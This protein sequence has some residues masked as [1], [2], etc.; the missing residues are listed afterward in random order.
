[1]FGMFTGIATISLVTVTFFLSQ[2]F[3]ETSWLTKIF[4][5]GG[6]AI[7]F[8][9]VVYFIGRQWDSDLQ[10]V[11][12]S[13]SKEGSAHL[14]NE[15]FS[16]LSPFRKIVDEVLNFDHVL[17]HM[18]RLKSGLDATT[19]NVMVADNE[20]N[21][22]YCNESM[23]QNFRSVESE[24]RK[25][26]PNFNVSKL[27]GEN[28]DVFHKNPAHQ[29]G[30]IQNL[31]QTVRTKIRVGTIHFDLIAT[32][33]ID[34]HR[35]RT[36]T[37]IEWKN[38][39]AE[40]MAQDEINEVIQK[41][42]D[43]V[44]DYRVSSANKQGFMKNL[45]DGLN[46]ITATFENVA[47]DVEKFLGSL[48]A[49]DLT[50]RISAQYQG[51]FDSIKQNANRAAEQI[52]STVQSIA[53]SA[54][55]V[56]TASRE[57]STGA[58]ELE[59]RTQQ[60]A[61]SLEETAASMEELTSTVRSN[62][63]NA[64][65]AQ[66]MAEAAAH[67]ANEGE[68]IVR[69]VVGSMEQIQESST[70]ISEIIQVIDKIAF[71]TNLLALNASVEA[72]RAGDHGKGFAVVAS[73]VRSLAEHSAQASHQIK[74][75]IESS[76]TQV[77]EGY[78]LVN[79]AGNSLNHILKN[80][81]DVNQMNREISIASNEQSTGLEQVN[82]V[83]AQL[84]EMTQKNASLVNESAAATK[85]L[86]EEVGHLKDLMSFFRS[87]NQGG[88]YQQTQYHNTSDGDMTFH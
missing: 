25:E 6:L 85:S 10:K 67:A 54:A 31:S 50:Q 63:E 17:K 72:A 73:E 9:G 49:G 28:M 4:V 46:N 16:S 59:Y 41:I 80:I 27:I 19:S 84:D 1:M 40:I 47:K 21:I 51:V 68:Q 38:V 3:T 65:K 66:E 5:G 24:L 62:A 8:S 53:Q 79:D 83:V 45:A 23:L 75:L 34:E 77:R 78:G 56:G 43:G 71:Q 52:E 69:R 30:M 44:L 12:L 26:L 64:R 2:L 13:F 39:T 81:Q 48:A 29:R 61:A 15:S 14:E 55:N 58:N 22:T 82:T 33:I 86:D 35:N 18:K 20:F 42:T 37:I 32:P 7:G 88:I 70:K 87:N 11:T 76:V 74:A 57:L 36:G 60:Q